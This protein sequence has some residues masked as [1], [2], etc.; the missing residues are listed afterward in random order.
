M[1]KAKV[2]SQVNSILNELGDE[3]ISKLPEKMYRAVTDNKD[4]KYNPEYDISKSLTNQGVYKETVAIICYFHK[5]FWCKDE[6]EKQFIEGILKMNSSEKGDE[7]SIFP[8]SN[9]EKRIKSNT[10]NAPNNSSEDIPVKKKKDIIDK[11]LESYL[12]L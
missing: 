4:N 8:G 11:F 5:N 10:K 12:D 9:D 1:D 3:Y 7:D 2:Y 6:K